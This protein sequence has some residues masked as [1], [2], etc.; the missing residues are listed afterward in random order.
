[1][2][3]AFYLYTINKHAMFSMIYAKISRARRAFW[4]SMWN[5]IYV[6]DTRMAINLG[7]LWTWCLTTMG[8]VLMAW[9]FLLG[10]FFANVDAG[11]F[12]SVPL[13]STAF[14]ILVT[15]TLSSIV[16]KTLK[17]C[18]MAIYMVMA[19]FAFMTKPFVTSLVF[20]YE[21][22]AGWPAENKKINILMEYKEFI[23][24]NW[25]L[26]SEVSSAWRIRRITISYL[27][28]LGR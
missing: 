26:I 13:K 24:S 19:I 27:I 6:S 8:R 16:T 7:T 1:M 10:K 5:R 4:T 18:D 11:E 14:S 12:S 22:S 9:I 3:S 15:I 21:F 25:G 17:A 2:A 28:K 20:Y 23:K